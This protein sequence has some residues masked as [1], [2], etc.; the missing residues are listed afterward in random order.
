MNISGKEEPSF[1]WFTKFRTWYD[2][3]FP[4]KALQAEKEKG[5]LGKADEE[6][7]KKEEEEKKEE[8]K[9]EVGSIADTTMSKITTKTASGHVHKHCTMKECANKRI[10]GNHWLRHVKDKHAGV[11]STPINCKED[12]NLC[13]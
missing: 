10:T 11:A 1:E 6:K 3:E 9:M 5:F 4:S 12:C 8:E 2:K 13:E 7:K